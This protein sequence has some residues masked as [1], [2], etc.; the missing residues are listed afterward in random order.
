MDASGVQVG[1]H[2][3]LEFPAQQPLGQ[4]QPDLVGQLRGGFPRCEALHQVVALH[5][6]QLVPLLFHSQHIFKGGCQ[7]AAQAGLEQVLF[8]VV[9]VHGLA[10]DGMEV[11][12]ILP[13]AG[14]PLVEG[15]LH[16]PLQPVDSDD[17]GVG[18]CSPPSFVLGTGIAGGSF[19]PS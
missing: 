17:A 8:G 13:A 11:F 2:H 4:F 10:Q 3:R 7:G 9:P 6:P 14:L 5:A 19:A 16:C 15:I 1:A 18:G 12:R